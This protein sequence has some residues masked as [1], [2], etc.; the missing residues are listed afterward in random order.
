[1]N[2]KITLLCLVLISIIF[3][4][5]DDDSSNTEAQEIVDSISLFP[6]PFVD[7]FEIY[8]ERRV[9][10]TFEVAVYDTSGKLEFEGSFNATAANNYTTTIVMD[11]QA[12]GL[13]LVEVRY[14]GASSSFEAVKDSAGNEL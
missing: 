3:H 8:V 12:D 7:R 2:K 5:C 13:Y 14:N 6:N 4:N 9:E 1:M 10:N 11:K